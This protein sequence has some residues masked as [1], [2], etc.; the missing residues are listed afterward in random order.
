MTRR[1]EFFI[2]L[3]EFIGIVAMS[4]AMGFLVQAAGIVVDG[5]PAGAAPL[6][7]C[8]F[9]AVVTVTATRA[10]PHPMNR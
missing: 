3:S 7:F 10:K 6:E 5:V 1:Q 2:V 8:V 9:V 4:Q